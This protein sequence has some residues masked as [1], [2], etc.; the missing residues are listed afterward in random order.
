ME[1]KGIILDYGGTI[2]TNGIH[3]L[4]V[5]H[6]MYGLA[7]ISLNKDTLRGAYVFAE[8]EMERNG[9]LVMPQDT[10]KE[11][12]RQKINYQISYLSQNKLT[13]RVK[14]FKK[15]ILIDYCYNFA[16][17]N[18]YKQIDTLS[19]L[20]SRYP[21]VLVSNFYGN[22]YSVL[23][24][25]KIDMYFHTVI[26]SARVGVRK[27]NPEIF[28]MGIKALNLNPDQVA[29]IG[30]SYTNDIAP[31]KEVGCTSIWLKNMGWNDQD[32]H[33]RTAD[34]V[35]KKLEDAIFILDKQNR[36]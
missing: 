19:K 11:N 12:L 35:I 24:D 4:E 23:K 36:A 30:D 17:Q 33:T 2:D 34:Y 15:N 3:W 29:I 1:I 6:K 10:F 13:T 31:A 5:F 7:G 25:F 16:R 9:H 18:T 20:T 32:D 8:Q 26:E 28:Q 14:D 21:M 27:P 22:L